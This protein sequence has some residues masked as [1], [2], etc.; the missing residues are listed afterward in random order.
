MNRIHIGPI[1]LYGCPEAQER[2]EPYLDGELPPDERRRVSFHLTICREC[3]P[4]FRFEARL[5][6]SVRQSL[7]EAE[8]PPELHAKVH[9]MLQQARDASQAPP[10]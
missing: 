10:E 8:P 4:L 3:A 5:D 9:S 6:G 2:L 7:N 1:D